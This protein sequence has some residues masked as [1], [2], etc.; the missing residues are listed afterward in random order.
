V[1]PAARVASRR[2]NW[3]LLN[4][5]LV[6]AGPAG[7]GKSC[8]ANEVSQQLRAAGVAHAVVDT[9]AL[10][11]V[12]PVPAEQW[13]ITERNLA[14]V[15]RT[16]TELGI[17]RLILTGVYMHRESELAWIRRATLAD[18]LTL[19]ELTAS[20]ATLMER[21]GRREIG[22]VLADQRGRTL[23]QAGEL[24]AE[25]SADV[26]VIETDNRSVSSTAERIVGLLGWG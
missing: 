25:R 17:D 6:N 15:W 5:V 11:D 23:R 22:S 26:V 19:V 2:L 9:D 12:Y 8:T 18:R 10:D 16:Y 20:E 3:A 21:V 1:S 13:R 14:S 4:D 7:V 24:E